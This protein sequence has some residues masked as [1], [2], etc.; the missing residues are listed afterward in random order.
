MNILMTSNRLLF[1]SPDESRDLPVYHKHLRED[2]DFQ[3]FTGLSLTDQHI[4]LMRLF[5]PYFYSLYVKE[6]NG[7]PSK[8]VG[9]IGY[10][11][12]SEE[13]EFYIFRPF[14]RQGFA[15]EAIHTFAEEAFKNGIP[16]NTNT[17][18]SIQLDHLKANTLRKNTPAISLLKSCGFQEPEEYILIGKSL[19]NEITGESVWLDTIDLILEKQ[20]GNSICQD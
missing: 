15:S 17:G 12:D 19:M 9:Y 4:E 14:R 13:I 1:L 5:Y 2:G 3:L 6:S 10:S 20:P 16:R 18:D 8:M 11:E 7:S